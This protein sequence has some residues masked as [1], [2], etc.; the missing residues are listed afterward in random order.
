LA[1]LFRFLQG[2]DKAVGRRGAA[3]PLNEEHFFFFV[4]NKK[5]LTFFKVFFSG[6]S[7]FF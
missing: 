2:F 4:R 5:F 7:Y 3:H 1:I 6:I